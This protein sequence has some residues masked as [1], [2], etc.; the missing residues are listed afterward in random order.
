MGPSSMI[1]YLNPASLCEAIEFFRTRPIET[2][3]LDR[4]GSRV[5]LHG[6]RR[7]LAVRFDDVPQLQRSGILPIFVSV[8]LRSKGLLPA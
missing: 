5:R 7:T 4:K 6:S 3:S 2:V 8:Y 1:I